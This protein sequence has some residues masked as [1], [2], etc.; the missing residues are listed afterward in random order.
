M[1]AKQTAASGRV[2]DMDSIHAELKKIKPENRN[3]NPLQCNQSTKI[4]L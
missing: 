2:L 4:Q 3:E 1:Q